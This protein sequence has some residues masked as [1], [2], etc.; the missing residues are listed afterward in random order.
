MVKARGTRLS[1]ATFSCRKRN[2]LHLISGKLFE[3]KKKK[4]G[5]VAILA[6]KKQQLVP[7]MSTEIKKI[8]ILCHAIIT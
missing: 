4:K 3:K 1:N 2:K 8:I 5:T 7:L 6:L